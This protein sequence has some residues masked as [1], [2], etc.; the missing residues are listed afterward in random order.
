MFKND[1]TYLG[2]YGRKFY[3][4]LSHHAAIYDRFSHFFW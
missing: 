1:H 2:V 3:I 4:K